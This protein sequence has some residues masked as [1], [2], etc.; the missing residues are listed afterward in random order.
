MSGFGGDRD[1][2]R[3]DWQGMAKARRGRRLRYDI[4]RHIEAELPRAPAQEVGIGD[5]IK[6]RDIEL[7]APA[8][9]RQSDVRADAGG[10]AEG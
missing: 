8:P 7:A 3:H 9:D 2:E 1:V 10:F 5:H 4:D 6:R